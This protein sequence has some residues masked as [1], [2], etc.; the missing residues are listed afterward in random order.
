MQK[1]SMRTGKYVYPSAEFEYLGHGP[2]LYSIAQSAVIGFD[3]IKKL[4]NALPMPN[5]TI[6]G[7]RIA[8]TILSIF[9]SPEIIFGPQRYVNDH[10]DKWIDRIDFFVHRNRPIRFSTLSFPF[11]IPMPLKT[12]RVLPDMGE[13]LALHRLALIAKLIKSVYKPGAT[14]T[15]FTEGA[16]APFAG[17]LESYA[18]AYETRLKWIT[19]KLGYSKMLLL[20]PVS[21]IE[22]IPRFKKTFRTLLTHNRRELDRKGSAV[23]RAYQESKRPMEKIVDTR[24]YDIETLKDVFNSKAKNV[25]TEVVRA[26]MDIQKRAKEA[27]AQYFSYLQTKNELDAIDQVIGPNLPLTISP[28]D[29]R[30]GIIPVDR[31]IN[32]LPIHGVTTYS[33]SNHQ[34]NIMYLNDLKRSPMSL[35][36]VFLRGDKDLRPFYYEVL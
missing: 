8:E 9:L 1:S 2:D 32:I 5:V 31:H 25:G 23:A 18:R 4:V 35:R 20:I 16:F 11:K 6:G 12:D 13:V 30:L 29:G 34:F 22:C 19:R 36:A 33:P 27:F 28:K 14:I 3:H 24:M 15:V 26:R 10:R 17:V 7:E 21:R